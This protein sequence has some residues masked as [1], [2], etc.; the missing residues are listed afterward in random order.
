VVGI[1]FLAVGLLR[2]PMIPVVAVLIPA[3][4]GLA[5]AEGRARG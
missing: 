4:I 3:S 1:T 5:W 2:W